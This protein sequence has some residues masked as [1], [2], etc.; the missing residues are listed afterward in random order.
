MVKQ[1][2]VKLGRELRQF[3]LFVGGGVLCDMGLG[4]WVLWWTGMLRSSSTTKKKENKKVM[5]YNGCDKVL[6]L[7]IRINH[8][9]TLIISYVVL[10]TVTIIYFRTRCKTCL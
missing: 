2:P 6:R 4:G 5:D 3:F 1:C 8:N 10:K 7:I 9:K